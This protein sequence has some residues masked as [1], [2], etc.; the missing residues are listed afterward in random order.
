MLLI[1]FKSLNGRAPSYPSELLSIHAPESTM[2]S[3]LKLMLSIQGLNLNL[4]VTETSLWQVP[5]SQTLE[6][7]K[8]LLK[9]HFFALASRT[10]YLNNFLFALIASSHCCS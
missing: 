7:F 6:N 4:T 8:S 5:D 1:V 9:T 10:C 3:S 2:R